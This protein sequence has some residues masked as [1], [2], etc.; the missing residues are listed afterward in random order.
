MIEIIKEII[1]IRDKQNKKNHIRLNP[2]IC[3]ENIKRIESLIEEK[4]P[5]DFIELY[6][7]AD[8]QVIED[9]PFIFDEFMS[10][11]QIIDSLEFSL[12][13]KKPTIPKI[14]TSE[15]CYYYLNR[16]K[17]LFISIIQKYCTSKWHRLE[18]SFSTGSYSGPYLF[19][20]C[21][22]NKYI[23]VDI[24]FE[25]YETL[26]PL[27]KELYNL[28]KD[29]YNWDEISINLF[30]NGSANFT[31]KYFDF[32]ESNF[33][34]TPNLTIKKKYFYYKWLPIFSDCSGNLIGIDLEP[35]TAGKKG[36][37]IVFG[38][39]EPNMFVAGE[40]LK[41]FF[42]VIKKIIINKKLINKVI[43]EDMH[44]HGLLRE[45]LYS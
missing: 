29:S 18:C 26:K 16:I 28:E 6:S 20:S 38:R 14:S 40:N 43:K 4:I 41:D 45:Y 32:G 10:S 42:N 5:D 35:D 17:D 15:M 8:G 1:D 21:D 3:S 19:S 33:S 23:I 36:Q 24:S 7:Y 31:R 13:L 44:I 12:K 9:Y 25:D 11:S 37:I 22:D 39:D 30:S 34:C 27:I 2:S